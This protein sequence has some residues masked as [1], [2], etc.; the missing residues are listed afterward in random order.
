M[1]RKGMRRSVI[2]KTSTYVREANVERLFVQRASERGWTV[3]KIIWVGRRGAPD[4]VLL[5]G[6]PPGII[7]VELKAPRGVLE[8][9][10]KREHTR[11]RA[12]GFAVVVLWNTAE[13]ERF[14]K[15]D[16]VRS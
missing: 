11:L 2:E 9:H 16:A 1:R 10:Q 6:P 15:I 13:V 3:R 5:R 4:R 12:M 8:A 14:F 7:F